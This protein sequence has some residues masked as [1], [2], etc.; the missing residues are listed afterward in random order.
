M[1]TFSQKHYEHMQRELH[2]LHDKLLAEDVDHVA[3]VLCLIF[4][5]DNPKFKRKMFLNY[6]AQEKINV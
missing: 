5:R 4:E 6:K 3:R 1:S 2:D